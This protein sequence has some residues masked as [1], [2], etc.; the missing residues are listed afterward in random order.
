MK[1]WIFILLCAKVVPMKIK[2]NLSN[3]IVASFSDTPVSLVV[4]PRQ[5]GKS[6]LVQMELDASKIPYITLDDPTHLQ[7][8]KAD[9]LGFL[10][11]LNHHVI[12]DEVQ[13]ALELLLP[14]KMLVDRRRDQVGFVLTGSANVLNLPKVADSLAGRMEIQTLWPLSQGEIEGRKEHFLDVLF[15]DGALPEV[16]P[17]DYRSLVERMTV[18]GFP[19]PVLRKNT[20]RRAQWFKSYLNALIQRDVRE[21]AHISHLAALPMLLDFLATRVSSLLNT[22][23]IS[24][25]S[26]ISATTL[27]RHLT[28]F[29]NIFLTV[30]LKPWFVRSDKRMVKTPKLYFNDTG[31]L[32][33]LLKLD[34]HTLLN[35]RASAGPVFE[36]FVVMEL[37][38][39]SAWSDCSPALFH[40]RNHS[41]DEVDIVLEANPHKLVGI[42]IKLAAQVHTDDFKGLKKLQDM[43]GDRFHRGI[44]L[45]TGSQVVVFSKQLTAVP[46]SA[47]WQY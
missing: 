31:I 47:L 46:V 8:A 33:S 24:R 13:R 19:E 21:L 12:I 2:R 25:M 11:H 34:A 35:Q 40:F 5:S 18:G 39:Q 20:K 6:T 9:P 44:V 14:M 7:A 38:K 29:E 22:A 16:P 27:K 15:S 1:Q 37:I 4:G 26:G 43:A 30:R 3:Q 23:D 17:C 28:L 42:E 10:E 36:N 45:Y 32:C 41:G